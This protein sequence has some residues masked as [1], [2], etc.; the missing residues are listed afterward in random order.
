[1]LLQ[2]K[3]LAEL[4]SLFLLAGGVLLTLV[5]LSR[6]MQMREL[7]LGLDLGLLD[8]IL[9]FSYM[10]PMFLLL[11][12]PISCMLSTFLTFLRMGTDR[13]L[14]ALRAGGVNIYQ[15]L[16]APLF[17]SFLCMLLTLWVSLHWQAWGLGSF[18]TLILEVAST[19]ARVVVQPGVFNVDF[20]NMVLFARQ[21]NSDTGEL[22][23][24]ML[25][26]RQRSERNLIILAPKGRIETIEEK[27]ELVFKLENGEIYTLNNKGT[28]ILAFDEYLVRLPLG[29]LFKSLDLGELRPME[30]TWDKLLNFSFEDLKNRDA[31]FGYKLL[32]EI[33]K[34]LAYPVACLAL[35]IFVMPLAAA[36][37]GLR[38]QTGLGLAL[39]MFFVYYG[40]MS[41]GFSLGET[42]TLPPAV[43]LW[44]P[45]F[46][47]LVAG[48]YGLWLTA[49]ERAPDFV[50]LFAKSRLKQWQSASKVANPFKKPKQIKTLPLDSE[51]SSGVKKGDL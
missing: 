47:F 20:P 33:H 37:H 14:V 4:A 5:T 50:N 12:I 34:R 31:N 45:N 11:V 44:M 3:I 42:G 19:R 9:L 26:D 49:Q 46:I 1:M 18:R 48:C 30:M 23:Q 39:V 51:A 10:I 43:G 36:F 22:T 41:L 32:V 27:A 17:F 16:P 38:R 21:V 13:E 24:V 15:L 40:L 25:D 8:T 7:F 29:S 28:S 35:T 2:R 6:V